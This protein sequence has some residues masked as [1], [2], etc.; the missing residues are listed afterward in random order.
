MTITEMREQ[1]IREKKATAAKK[2][3]ERAE[4]RR[5]KTPCCLYFVVAWN[6]LAEQWGVPS[7]TDRTGYLSKESAEKAAASLRSPWVQATVC[8]I[9]VEIKS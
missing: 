7:R 8:E 3:A 6:W 1:V 2:E 4:Q 5:P 9:K